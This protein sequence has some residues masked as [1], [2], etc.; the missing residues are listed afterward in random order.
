MFLTHKIV[1]TYA[2]PYFGSDYSNPK[3][4]GTNCL[5]MGLFTAGMPAFSHH[6]LWALTQ[7]TFPVEKMHKLTMKNPFKPSS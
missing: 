6:A 1:I 5:R 7:P 3:K 2:S 4:G